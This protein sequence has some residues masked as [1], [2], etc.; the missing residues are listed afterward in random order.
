MPLRRISVQLSAI[1]WHESTK[2][3]TL[4][5]SDAKVPSTLSTRKAQTHQVDCCIVSRN[6][7]ITFAYV[8]SFLKAGETNHAIN[9]ENGKSEIRTS[10]ARLKSRS[11]GIPF[12]ATVNLKPLDIR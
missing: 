7:K 1:M 4:G 5:D 2:K 9:G 10:A 3:L 6:G 8:Q 11:P 12:K